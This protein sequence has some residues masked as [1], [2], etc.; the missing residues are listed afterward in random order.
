[1]G[2]RT[3]RVV[4]APKPKNEVDSSAFIVYAQWSRCCFGGLRDH[5]A[6]LADGGY[7]NIS[8][9]QKAHLLVENIARNTF[10][11]DWG[12]AI[13]GIEIGGM[14]DESNP[15]VLVKVFSHTHLDLLNESAHSMGFTTADSE[16]SLVSG[17]PHGNWVVTRRWLFGIADADKGKYYDYPGATPPGVRLVFSYAE[18]RSAKP[19]SF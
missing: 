1:M 16:E 15:H 13:R 18:T 8:D 4:E 14:N 2:R 19:E 5:L 7:V 3:Q 10:G 17:T 11:D 12:K 9:G 6:A